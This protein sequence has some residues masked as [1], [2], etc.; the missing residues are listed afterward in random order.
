MPEWAET[1]PIAILIAL[2][3]ALQAKEQNNDA[4]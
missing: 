3:T 2:L 1:A 4:G